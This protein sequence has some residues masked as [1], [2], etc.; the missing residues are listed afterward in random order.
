MIE[1]EEAVAAS[2]VSALEVPGSIRRRTMPSPAGSCSASW[3]SAGARSTA[4]E[5]R[6]RG[7]RRRPPRRR[8][9]AHPRL[10]P[11]AGRSGAIASIATE[12]EI[13]PSGDRDQWTITAIGLKER[14]GRHPDQP[15]LDD[16]R[17]QRLELG[18]GDRALAAQPVERVEPVDRAAP[19]REP[20]RG[21]G[22]ARDAPG[23]TCCGSAAPAQ[24]E[25]QQ[26]ARA[27]DQAHEAD[28]QA[29]GL[30]ARARVRLRPPD[31]EKAADREAPEKAGPDPDDHA[32]VLR[33][34]GP[35]RAAR[36]GRRR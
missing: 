20:R 1:L 24:V 13:E 31:G 21:P 18:V 26:A 36:R 14:L 23:A 17:L 3:S 15:S 22:H 16:L 30:A 28:D 8:R 5:Q 12:A 11:S 32:A 34:C 10:D 4:R 27:H 6:I 7:R 29:A 9:G 35:S 25:R 2:A 33:A 19:R